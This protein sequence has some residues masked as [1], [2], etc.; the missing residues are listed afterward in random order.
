[1]IKAIIFDFDGVIVESA[2]IKT[3][4]FRTLF[5]KR[6]PHHI[7]KIVNYHKKNMGISRYEKFKSIY[8]E[9]DG[10]EISNEEE[11][12]LNEEFSKIVF[13]QVVK[14]PMVTGVM[15]FLTEHQG[16]YLLFIASGT[17]HLELLDILQSRQ[18]RKYFKEV[19]GTPKIKQDIIT[20][21][22]E[23][24][25]LQAS[26]IVFVG[27]A[28]SDLKAAFATSVH[29][30]ARISPHAVELKKCKHQINNLF[31]L[32]ALLTKLNEDVKIYGKE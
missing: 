14:A 17:P 26:E 2:D 19:Y 9:Y 6:F 24:Y 21:I 20:D 22:M 7:E 11:V 4:A 29:F 32:Y 1:M 16:A 18:L 10:R 28:E 15:E 31:H 8:R 5:E 12:K 3:D 25:H 27:D 30:V 13:D 23:R